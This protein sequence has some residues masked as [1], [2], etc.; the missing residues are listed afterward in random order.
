MYSV[1]TK[2]WKTRGQWPYRL[3]STRAME[4]FKHLQTDSEVQFDL[5]LKPA[6]LI[7][8]VS[9]SIT[10]IL[11]ASQAMAASK[12][13][14]KS[15]LTSELNSVTSTALVSMCI[16]PLTVI[17]VASEAVA[18]S[19]RPQRS[20]LTSELKSVTSITYVAMLLWPLTA[21]SDSILPGQI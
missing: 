17:L 19:K 14:Q 5:D 20:H 7:T 11:I 16:L 18:S 13:P 2:Q 15:Y 4:N 6:T 12:R 21:S 8:L 9:M 3:R 1:Q 10:V